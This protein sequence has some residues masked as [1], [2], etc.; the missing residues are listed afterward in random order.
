VIS[1]LTFETYSRIR[2]FYQALLDKAHNIYNLC[3]AYLHVITKCTRDIC[4]ERERTEGR[5]G[6]CVRLV[7]RPHHDRWIVHV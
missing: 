5:K 7:Q 3:C 2:V 1:F 6:S 4:S